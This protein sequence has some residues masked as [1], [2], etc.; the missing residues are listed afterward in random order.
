MLVNVLA[1]VEQ[2]L[3]NLT[4]PAHCSCDPDIACHGLTSDGDRVEIA[5]HQPL[6]GGCWRQVKAGEENLLDIKPEQA[7]HSSQ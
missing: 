4:A 3:H 1:H 7:Q 2:R 5:V 6:F